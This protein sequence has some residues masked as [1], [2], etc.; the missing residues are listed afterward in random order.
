V[1]ADLQELVRGWSRPWRRSDP[2]EPEFLVGTVKT[3]QCY[4][5]G[6]VHLLRLTS[7][8]ESLTPICGAGTSNWVHDNMTGTLHAIT[9]KRCLAAIKGQEVPTR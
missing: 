8:P 6:V 1:S 3:C 2:A 5:E 9:C 7:D 4:T